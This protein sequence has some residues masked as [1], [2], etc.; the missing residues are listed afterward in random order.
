MKTAGRIKSNIIYY[1]KGTVK[2]V[3]FLVSAVTEGKTNTTI[4]AEDTA[5]TVV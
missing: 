5:F 3:S 1:R 2:A 4:S